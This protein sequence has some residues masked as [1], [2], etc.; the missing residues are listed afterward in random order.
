MLKM[1]RLLCNSVESLLRH[2]NKFTSLHKDNKI[3]ETAQCNTK[4]LVLGRISY[5]N[6]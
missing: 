4:L 6:K 1:L 3:S 2:V 5:V